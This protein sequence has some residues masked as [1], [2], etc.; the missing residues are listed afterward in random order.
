[1]TCEDAMDYAKQLRLHGRTGHLLTVVDFDEHR[2][3]ASN[4][5][6][7]E[8][9]LPCSYFADQDEWRWTAG[10]EN[11]KICPQEYPQAEELSISKWRVPNTYRYPTNKAVLHWTSEGWQ[12]LKTQSKSKFIV[13]FSSVSSDDVS[14]LRD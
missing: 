13:E 10:P 1:M 7:F 8:S 12:E 6:R 4:F 2:F 3:L 11:E 5:R 14:S 9:H